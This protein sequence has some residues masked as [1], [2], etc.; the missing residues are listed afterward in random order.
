METQEVS[1]VIMEVLIREAPLYPTQ[2]HVLQ[3]NIL[4]TRLTVQEGKPRLVEDS[5]PS[6]LEDP[7]GDHSQ[8]QQKHD[9][10]QGCTVVKM[11]AL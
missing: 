11:C 5:E 10:Q 9:Q 3:I 8:K 4:L 1:F 6:N 7:Y 2:W